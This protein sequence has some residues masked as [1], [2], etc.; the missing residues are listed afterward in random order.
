MIIYK[1]GNI[2]NSSAQVITNPVNCVGVM[3]KGLALI[4][5]EKFPDMYADYKKR[6]SEGAVILGKPY[7]WE[8]DHV[9]IMNFPTKRHWKDKSLLSDIEEGL[10]YVSENY[11]K[12]GITSLS[13]PA[14]GSGLGGLNWFDVKNLINKYLG[15]LDDLDVYVYE[16][17]EIAFDSMNDKQHTED[18]IKMDNGYAAQESFTGTGTTTQIAGTN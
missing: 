11:R 14:L 13:L 8:N 3:G 6:C 17:E 5:K 4:Y 2:F 15:A 9:Q 1:T 16:K 12:M 18:P 10:K 7:L